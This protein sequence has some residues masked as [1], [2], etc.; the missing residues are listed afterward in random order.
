[1][2]PLTKRIFKF[3]LDRT[4]GGF[5]EKKL[6]LDQLEIS[7]GVLKLRNIRLNVDVGVSLLSPDTSALVFLL[8][9]LPQTFVSFLIVFV[10]VLVFLFVFPLPLPLTS[11]VLLPS[12][13]PFLR[14]NRC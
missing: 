11:Y 4:I 2:D 6:D 7:L 14:I 3:I 10:S 13:T 12:N 8:T 1:M 9:F 5:L